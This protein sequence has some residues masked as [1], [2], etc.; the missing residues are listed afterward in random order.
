MKLTD[1]FE[2]LGAEKLAAAVPGCNF[3][4]KSKEENKK[5]IEAFLNAS[6]EILGS[7]YQLPNEAFYL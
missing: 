4:I 3:G 5:A 6:N 7:T 2:K 1:N